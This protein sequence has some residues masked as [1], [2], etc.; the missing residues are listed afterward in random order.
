MRTT[1]TKSLVRTSFLLAAAA[2]SIAP[3]CAANITVTTG[4]KSIGTGGTA[5]TAT[6]IVTVNGGSLEVTTNSTI[7]GLSGTGGEVCS[8]FQNSAYTHST[9]TVN[10]AAGESYIYNGT[11]RPNHYDGVSVNR[12]TFTKTGQGTQELAGVLI[13]YLW[14]PATKP[15]LNASGGVL[16]LSGA[17]GFDGYIDYSGAVNVNNG[18]T[19][20]IARSWNYGSGN[21]FNQLS[22]NAQNILVSNGTLRF[23]GVDQSSAR[24]FTVG[25]GGATL[26]VAEGISFSNMTGAQVGVISGSAGGNLTLGG[27]SVS[28]SLSNA[29]GSA[30]TW[31]AGA[32]LIKADLGTWTVAGVDD[33]MSGGLQVSQGTLVLTAN[34][35]YTAGTIIQ[36]GGTLEVRGTLGSG[37]Y[38][39]SIANDGGLVFNSS[40][41]Q[42]L[43]GV[44]SGVG[45]LETKGAGQLT[46]GASNTYA[47]DTIVTA[48]SLRLNHVDAIKY[49]NLVTNSAAG[50]VVFGVAAGT[51][52]VGALS[53]NGTLAL[54]DTA[55]TP[56]AITLVTGNSNVAES[57]SGVLSGLGNLRKAGTNTLTLTGT[58]TYA[59]QTIV[60]SGT[61]ALSG[62]GT[63]GSGVVQLNGGALDLGAVTVAFTNSVNFNGGVL[64][65]GSMDVAQ[66][67]S[68]QSGTVSTALTGTG[69]LTKTGAGL[70]VLGAGVTHTYSGQT[71]VNEG[72]LKLDGIIASSITVANGASLGGHGVINGNVSMS[73]G[74]TIAAGGSVGNLTVGSLTI[75]SGTQVAWEVYDANGVAG[76]DYDKITVNGALDLSGL[77]GTNRATLVL[78]SLSDPLA[79]LPG[80]AGLFDAS[81]N[82]TFTLFTYGSLNLGSNTDVTSLFSID[83]SSVRDAAGV[84]VAGDFSLRDSGTSIDLVYAS[85]V[86]EPSTYGLGLGFLALAAVAVRRQR[87]KAPAQT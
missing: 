19:L 15:V 10:V 41:A 14:S 1:T 68:A 50:T 20:E 52:N 18:G 66:V 9:L 49:S 45:S 4:T 55:A 78:S 33:K 30:G 27:E 25:S 77:S 81:L 29:V 26:S 16:K 22:H 57:F 17:W 39:G 58:N 28:A 84:L 85:P 48:G 46:L 42:D 2:F 51:Y 86:P 64:T 36:T 13:G 24:S 60:S 82:H 54:S 6:D 59:G 63:L 7:G 3:V 69:G 44:I 62:A 11:I 37:T 31:A 40:S 38:A 74:S 79:N 72:K 12:L 56:G 65:G 43:N 34:S 21:A 80:N 5:T 61:L 75:T 8:G 47:G 76:V 70:L 71:L 87:R 73:A 53:G 35:S 23:S 32:K 67:A 83:K